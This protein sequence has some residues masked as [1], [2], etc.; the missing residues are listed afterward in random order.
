M[1]KVNKKIL[2]AYKTQ[3]GIIP[4]LE[5]FNNLKDLSF[6]Q[7]IKRRLDRLELGNFG[8]C[9]SVGAGV[10]ELRFKFGPGYRIYFTEKDDVIIIL[11]CGGDK[12]SQKK[13]IKIAKDYMRDLK[14]GDYEQI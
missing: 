2:R 12:K 1:R 4:F 5:W 13:D 10:L 7:R 6:K 8:D 11:L 14:E 3:I 9:E